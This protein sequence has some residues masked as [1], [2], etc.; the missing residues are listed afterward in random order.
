MFVGS[1]AEGSED[2]PPFEAASGPRAGREEEAEKEGK[3][4]K[5]KKREK[6]A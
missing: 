1:I 2:S 6:K 4:K 5:R 3:M